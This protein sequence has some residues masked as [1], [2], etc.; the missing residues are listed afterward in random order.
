[1][2]FLHHL[3]AESWI[4]CG[5]PRLCIPSGLS[6]LFCG[7]MHRSRDCTLEAEDSSYPHSIC[8]CV[9]F[10]FQASSRPPRYQG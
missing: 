9:T 10:S 2:D 4:S 1:M 5:L 8:R 3:F 6:V 7:E